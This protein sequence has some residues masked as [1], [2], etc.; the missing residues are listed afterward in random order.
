[1]LL[2]NRTRN[3]TKKSINQILNLKVKGSKKYRNIFDHDANRNVADLR[4]VQTFRDLTG[5]ELPSTGI[6]ENCTGSWAKNYL[7]SDIKM[8]VFR[9][10]NNCLPLSNRVHNFNRDI[11]PTCVFCRIRNINARESFRH[12]FWSCDSAATWRINFINTFFR[13]VGGFLN[14]EDFFW[15]GMTTADQSP[16]INSVTNTVW[17]IFRYVIFKFKLRCILPNFQYIKNEFLFLLKCICNCNG[18]IS[19]VINN[20]PIFLQQSQAI[21]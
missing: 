16:L 6:L 14:L 7:P 18:K 8:F 1:M 2:K 19:T 11:N 17:D 13:G 5:T 20:L 4:T 12:C 3:K 21:G 10:R 9:F 15:Y